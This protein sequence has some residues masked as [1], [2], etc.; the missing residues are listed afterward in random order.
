MNQ[1]DQSST[2]VQPRMGIA[3]R[4]ISGTTKIGRSML[5]VRGHHE[6]LCLDGE[7]SIEPRYVD[8]GSSDA[9]LLRRARHL[10]R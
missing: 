2:V 8:R 10:R 7:R 1:I 3:G 9:I 6:I 4:T 5:V